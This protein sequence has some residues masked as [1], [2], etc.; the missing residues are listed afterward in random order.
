MDVYVLTT[1]FSDRLAPITEEFKEAMYDA[2][3][4]VD[5]P[6]VELMT[7]VIPDKE[8]RRKFAERVVAEKKDPAHHLYTHLYD[9]FFE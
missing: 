1:N 9:A 8:E 2:F 4:G 3:T 5:P 6:L 7:P